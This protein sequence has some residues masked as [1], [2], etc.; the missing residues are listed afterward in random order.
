M[1]GLGVVFCLG[2]PL[3]AAPPLA[4]SAMP[5]PVAIHAEFELI[6]QDGIRRTERDYAGKPV[7]LFFGY[8][9]CEAI[10]SV[11]LPRLAG[12]IDL[13]GAEGAS[14]Q[15]I[16]ITVDPER[17]TPEALKSSLPR[18]HPRLIGLTGSETELAA[19][20]D[21]FQVEAKVVW[22]EPDGDPIYAHG[23]FI[24]LLGPDGELKTLIPPIL[25][26]ARIAEL[27]RKYL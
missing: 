7:V 26:E 10:C 24:Y 9:N 12:A 19:V 11:A 13:L 21:V 1:A 18:Y 16:L 4:E 3:N 15:P 8:A 17:D 20:R 6:D 14:I 23:S 2:G 27:M 5:F 25:G 22:R